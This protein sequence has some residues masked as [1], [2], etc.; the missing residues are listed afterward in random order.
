MAKKEKEV[1]EPGELGKVRERLGNIED[2]EAKRLAQLLGGDIGTE[3]KEEKSPPQKPGHPSSHGEGNGA[4][5]PPKRRI[6]TAADEEDTGPSKKPPVSKDPMDNPS[7]PIKLSYWERVKMDKYAG[8]AEF[9]IKSFGQVLHSIFSFFGPPTDYLNARF[10]NKRMN[11]YY[12]RIGELVTA[13]RALFP[14]N[15]LGRNERL[16]KASS[17]AYRVLDTIR[18][19]NIERM[20]ADLTRMQSRPRSVKLAEFADIL[21]CVYQPLFV[22]ERLDLEIH[23]KEAYKLLYRLNSLE[24]PQE[25]NESHLELIRS[26]LAALQI[27]RKDIRFMLYPLLVK[28]LSDR[29]LPYNTFFDARRN[30]FLAFIG[31]SAANQILPI[32]SSKVAEIIDENQEEAEDH[33]EDEEVVEDDPEVEAKKARLAIVEAEQKAV[34]KGLQTLEIL[35]PQAGWDRLPQFPDMYP[36]FRGVFSLKK[37][38]ALIAPTDPVLQLM[39][40]TRILEEL[41]FGLRYTAFG[42]VIT[43]DGTP[44]RLED[45]L[46]PIINNWHYAIENSFDKEYLPRLVEYCR[47]L[48]NTAESRTSNYAR[49]LLNEL[50]WLKRLYFLPYYKFESTIP[51]PFHKQDITPLYPEIRQLR[52]YLTAVAAGIEQGNKNGGAAKKAPCDGIDNPWEHYEF[53]VPNPLS[54]R[55]DALLSAEKRNNASLIFFT[56]AVTVVTDN[57]INSDA[58]WAYGDR[59]GTLFRSVNGEGV[60]PAP[61]VDETVDAEAIFK[62]SLKNA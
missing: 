28:L 30:R 22:L 54:K 25:A 50:H 45:V 9:D 49:R 60:T 62:Q 55:L 44:E 17:F 14:R 6:I 43:S 11:E 1:Y 58:S 33:A 59:P 4:K 40:F 20:S 61:G 27:I 24:N 56:L 12:K 38:Y 18:Q 7:I 16:K 42:V 15:N 23:I 46:T 2:T 32:E 19:W 57:F 29:W 13:T 37:E 5:I 36:Y 8:Q 34:D 48:E 52:K 10:I 47:I 41:L 53:Q 31:M 51:P 26:A 35:F 21:R 39:I 3:R